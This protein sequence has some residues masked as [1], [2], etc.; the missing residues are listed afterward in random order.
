MD[1]LIDGPTYVFTGDLTDRR[2][3]KQS[4]AQCKQNKAEFMPI[5]KSRA[6]GA[7]VAN[8]LTD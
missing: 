8:V 5:P 2:S 7:Y 6:G 4:D 1:D 3:E